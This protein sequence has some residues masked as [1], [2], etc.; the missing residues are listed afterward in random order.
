VEENET[1]QATDNKNNRVLWL[2]H[3]LVAVVAVVILVVLLSLQPWSESP[4]TSVN[5]F[6]M[7][8]SASYAEEDMFSVTFQEM[9][10][11]SPAH[12]HI[13]L[14][15]EDED[16]E[17]I[18]I[19]ENL[20]ANDERYVTGT[21]VGMSILMSVASIIPSEAHTKMT[22]D[23]LVD[24]EELSIE[25]VSGVTCRHYQGRMDLVKSIE[26]QI[27]SLDPE[28][29]DYDAILEV[30]EAQIESL[31]EIKTII[32]VWVGRGDGFV[33]QIRYEAQMPSDYS[34]SPAVSIQSMKYYDINKSINIEAPLDN[35]GE[36]LPG[37]YQESF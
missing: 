23:P 9:S 30:L 18:I 26:E 8:M 10:Y 37:W 20:Y 25:R 36:L 15:P 4:I 34:E 31:Q 12:A 22:M 19:G 21:G 6:R 35:D 28:Q 24:V 11:S 29:Q 16:Q 14:N 33:R 3:A 32:D 13:I 5:S 2:G 27:A 17:I 7:S 1:N